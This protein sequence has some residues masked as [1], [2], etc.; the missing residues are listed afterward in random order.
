VSRDPEFGV[1]GGAQSRVVRWV[2]AG[3][4]IAG[5][6]AACRSA[7]SQA[8]NA[9]GEEVVIWKEVG[10]WSGHGN[11]QTESFTSDTGGFRVR[12]ETTNESPPGSGRLKVVFRSGDSG[13]PIIDAL[14]VHG[15]GRDAIEVADN[16]RW[17]FLTIES[18]GVDWK[19]SVDERLRGQRA[20]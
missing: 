7:A 19:V 17:Y 12:W 10:S 20:Q 2:I 11:A 8:D 6:A 4:L 9:H 18:A 5:M 3:V 14:D 1:R 13:R 15:V 16:V